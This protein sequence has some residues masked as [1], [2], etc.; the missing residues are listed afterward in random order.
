MKKSMNLII[1]LA[2]MGFNSCN[3]TVYQEVSM[4]SA[5]TVQVEL[6]PELNLELDDFMS[7]DNENTLYVNVINGEQCFTCAPVFLMV[8]EKLVNA[9]IPSEN[10][11]YIFPSKRKV[12]QKDFLKENFGLDINK[13]KVIFSDEV[14]DL[15]QNQYALE[16]NSNLLCLNQNKELLS[17][18]TY[19]RANFNELFSVIP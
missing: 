15:I 18:T 4:K 14:Y 5:S 7:T 9:N 11:V 12:L 8:A 19:Q 16:G 17:K 6:S 1:I 10:L 3:Y 2:F 13:V